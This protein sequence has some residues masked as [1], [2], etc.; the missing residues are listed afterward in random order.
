M[1]SITRSRFELF[2]GVFFNHVKTDKFKSELITVNFL[3]ALDRDTVSMNTLIP[4]VLLRGTVKHPTLDS[5]S[6]ATD[7]LYGTVLFPLSRKLGEIL[8]V[9]IG[10]GFVSGRLTPEGDENTAGVV[11]LICEVICNP[12]MK[13]GRFV[14]EFVNSEKEKLLDDIAS[15]LN[16]KQT[17]AMAKAVEFM[18]ACEHYGTDEY[19]TEQ[20]AGAITRQK[21]SERYRTLLTSSPIEI[22][23]CGSCETERIAEAFRDRLQ[24]IVAINPDYD[25][26]TDIRMDPLED[27]VRYYEEEM[28]IAQGKFVIGYRLGDCMEEPDY[29]AIRVFNVLFG[30]GVTSKL[31]MNVREKL[32]LA[33]YAA[34]GTDMLKGLI[35][36]YS[37]IDGENYDKAVREIGI[38]LEAIRNGD[39]TDEELN[40]AIATVASGHK[41]VPDLPASLENFCMR[42]LL[43][44]FPDASPEEFCALAGEVTREDVIAI[45][46]SVRPDCIFYLKPS[47]N[48]PGEEDYEEDEDE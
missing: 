18:C 26:G 39:F 8:A 33:Y 5:I 11:D 32:S 7:E 30:G 13:S 36:V 24:N 45:A 29:E 47:G 43:M 22:F 14:P 3:T 23:Y 15:K 48:L 6:A 20:S 25:I 10:A 40:N 9:G 4:R 37:G 41:S 28:D 12:L 34:S 31:F 27:E 17:Y 46:K 38:Q 44:G 1:E 19:G 21:L 42:S 35:F 16:D 2:P